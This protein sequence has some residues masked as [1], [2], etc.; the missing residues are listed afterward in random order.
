MQVLVL[1]LFFVLTSQN[2][3][4]NA[5]EYEWHEKFKYYFPSLE[6]KMREMLHGRCI[7][8]Y[9]QLQDGVI[10]LPESPKNVTVTSFPISEKISDWWKNIDSPRQMRVEPLLCDTPYS[11]LRPIFNNTGCVTPV[12]YMIQSGPRCQTDYL[13]WICKNARIPSNVAISNGFILPESNHKST[14]F[15]PAPY[16]LTV[17][18][19]FVSMC[20]QISNRCGLIATTTN[21]MATLQTKRMGRFRRLCKHSL[22][23]NKPIPSDSLKV[24]LN[25][26][27][28]TP[29]T[30]EIT[31]VDRVFVVAEADDTHVYHVHLEIMPR[32]IYHKDFLLANP[33]IMIL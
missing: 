1:L 26:P 28:G 19:S 32:I 11:K 9:Q 6:I 7:N 14:D 10:R 12:G 20:G 31:Y 4:I 33:D 22:I 5:T 15:P 3:R 13:K 18:E 25:C 27:E 17:R 24:I 2:I 29:F 23:K 8:T 30:N 16:L 21:C